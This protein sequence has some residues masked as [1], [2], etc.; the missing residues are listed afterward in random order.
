[1][2]A[3]A[4]VDQAELRLDAVED[5]VR[6]FARGRIVVVV[7]DADRENEGDLICAASTV[8]P[9]DIAFIVRY[10][11]G[12]VCAPMAGDLLDR[13]EIPLMT[14]R[15][16]DRMSTAFTISVDARD[17]ISTG[18]SAADRAKTL[19]TLVDPGSRPDDLVQPGH[20]FPLRA[21]GNGV[22]DRPGHTEAAVDLARLADLPPA[23]VLAELVND[24]GTMMRGQQLR[25]FAD[26]HGLVLISIED[27][28]ATRNRG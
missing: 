11:T 21:A 26:A 13:L 22:L 9:A 20:I 3:S 24:D 7:D 10:T 28:I 17:G 4:T 16:R 14:S 6:A 19:R 1:M 8:T 2:S 23:G 27:L 12:I 18:V 15:N 5:A 25:D